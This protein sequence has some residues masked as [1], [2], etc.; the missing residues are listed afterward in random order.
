MYRIDSRVE[1]LV[2]CIWLFHDLK[3]LSLTLSDSRIEFWKVQ[4]E[5]WMFR[6]VYG[7]KRVSYDKENYWA[8]GWGGSSIGLSNLELS[9][10]VGLR[11][12]RRPTQCTVR[13]HAVRVQTNPYGH[14]NATSLLFMTPWDRVCCSSSKNIVSL[15]SLVDLH[16]RSSYVLRV[17]QMSVARPSWNRIDWF[18]C[19]RAL[20]PIVLHHRFVESS[21]DAPCWDSCGVVS[22][23][24]I[25]KSTNGI[26]L[27]WQWA[28]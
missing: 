20:S 22:P 3:F 10:S 7:R 14:C 1:T 5:Y 17:R 25:P 15:S 19:I 16:Q 8:M 2:F 9:N 4:C 18:R 26:N 24:T 28:Q 6:M 21:V 11:R 27:G 13:Y 23:C 12:K